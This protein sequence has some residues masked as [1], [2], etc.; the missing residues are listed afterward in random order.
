MTMYGL[1]FGQMV[2]DADTVLSELTHS[3][4]FHFFHLFSVG[5]FFFPTK[6]QHTDL[7]IFDHP[8][9]IV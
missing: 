1:L 6:I 8:L 4:L 7:C 2:T 5:Y 3:N 9:L